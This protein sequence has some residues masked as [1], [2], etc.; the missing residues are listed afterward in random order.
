MSVIKRETNMKVVTLSFPC[1]LGRD[2]TQVG[3]KQQRMLVRQRSLACADRQARAPF[4]D[5]KLKN[6]EFMALGIFLHAS[7]EVRGVP[8][9]PKQMRRI[10]G[11][12]HRLQ[13][14]TI[15]DR[16]LDNPASTVFPNEHIPTRQQRFRLRT[17]VSERSEEH[18]SELQS[19]RHI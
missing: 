8:M 2:M 4:V 3:V 12:F 19:L 5:A 14:V 10:H 9:Q 1:L 17:E 15:D 13:P 18:T 16:F 6:N 7:C 11:I